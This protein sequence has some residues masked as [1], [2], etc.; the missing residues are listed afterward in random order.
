VD[1]TDAGWG[2]VPADRAEWLRDQRPPHWDG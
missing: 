2:E 1:D